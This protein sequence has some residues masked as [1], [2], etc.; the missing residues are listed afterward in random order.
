MSEFRLLGA[1]LAEAVR[2]HEGQLRKTTAIP[3]ISHPL[4]VCGLVLEA[5]G[6]EAEAVAALLH[7]T[8]E[9]VQIPGMSG[10][11]VLRAIETTFGSE[12]A[13]IVRA[14]SDALPM[15]GAE[16]PPWS[17]RKHAY[18]AHLGTASPSTLLVSAADKLHNLRSIFED[19]Q[20]I[21]DEIWERFSPPGD[22][23]LATLWYHRA[24]YDVYVNP[25]TAPDPRR[26]RLTTAMAN[27]LERLERGS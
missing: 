25:A 18:L 7:D 14:C 19:W 26:E 6:N 20:R 21:G 1:A 2:Y 23:R 22:K 17:E 8:A 11:D 24:L 4:A 10:S 9:D 12:V 27:V 15:A 16:K 13:A 3:Y 5:G